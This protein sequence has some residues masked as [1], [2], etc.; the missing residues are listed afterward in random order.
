MKLDQ[1]AGVIVDRLRAAGIRATL[2]ERDI[3]PP[4]VWIKPPTL[5][6]RF[7]KGWTAT[8]TVQAVVP[9]TGRN[10]ALA[11]LGTLVEAVQAALG[12]AAQTALPIALLIPGGAAPLPGYELTFNE[13]IA[14]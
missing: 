14:P 9:D 7:G 2:D 12:G 6:F 8:W 1:A 10:V 3:N 5:T 13:R 4:A 11:A